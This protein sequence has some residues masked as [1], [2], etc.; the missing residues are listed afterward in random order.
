M[1]VD[2]MSKMCED[3]YS[4]S[5]TTVSKY[6]RYTNVTEIYKPPQNSGCKMVGIEVP[7]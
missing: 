6:Q 3:M 5:A 1:A 7:N 4:I 2:A